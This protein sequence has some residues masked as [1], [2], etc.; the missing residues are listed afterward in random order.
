VVIAWAALRQAGIAA[1]RHYAQTEADRQRRITES[2]SKAVE[3]LG[4]DK[5]ETRL[6]GIYTLERIS[7]E[8]PTDYWTIMETLTAFVRE[9]AHW[10]KPDETISEMMDRL[11]KEQEDLV[12][13][14]RIEPPTDIAA[15]LAVIVRRRETDRAREKSEGWRLRLEA[16]DLRGADLAGAHLEGTFLGG[17]HLEWAVLLDAHLKK[18]SFLQACLG[19][20]ILSGGNLEGAYLKEAH[21]EGVDLSATLGLEQAQLNEAHG[22]A[23]TMLPQGLTRPVHWLPGEPDSKLLSSTN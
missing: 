1:R 21:L 23:T 11:Y 16:T 19:G 7:R 22:D 13:G 2:F 5:I 3:Q 12:I 6:G 15:V 4:S 9:R 14:R 18:T 10:T 20:A 8:S 17:S